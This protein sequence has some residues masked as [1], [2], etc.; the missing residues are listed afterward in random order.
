MKYIRA[1]LKNPF[2]TW[3]KSLVVSFYYEYKYATKH[4]AI[5]YMTR[6]VNCRFGN[7][8]TLYDGVILTNVMLGDFSYVAANSNLANADIGKFSCI[9]PEV[10]AGIGKHPSRNFVSTHP[11]FYSPSLQTQIS[12]ASNSFYEEF[13]Q[14]KIGNDVWIGARAIILDG[15]TIGD[16]AIVGAG[17]VVT[18]DVPAYAVVGG[19]P[20]KILRYRFEPAEIEFLHQFKWWDQDI[21]WLRENHRLFHDIKKFCQNQNNNQ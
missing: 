3:I 14:I 20:A 6:L 4:L 11:I 7:Y 15:V 13:E 10:F 21:L 19:V 2:T 17:A 16:G 1:I 18:K 8:N 5:G 9:G 12:F